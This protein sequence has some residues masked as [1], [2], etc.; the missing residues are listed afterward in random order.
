MLKACHFKDNLESLNGF[1]VSDK[2]QRRER[3]WGQRGR[4]LFLLPF[5]HQKPELRNSIVNNICFLTSYI[6][7]GKIYFST[8]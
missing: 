5:S 3:D 7:F 1:C 8:L 2:I 6:M 4:K